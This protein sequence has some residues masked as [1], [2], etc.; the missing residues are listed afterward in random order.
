MATAMVGLGD[1]RFQIDVSLRRRP[2]CGALWI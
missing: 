2:S 1:L